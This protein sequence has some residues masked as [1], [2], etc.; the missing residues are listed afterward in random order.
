MEC[1]MTVTLLMKILCLCM[2]MCVYMCAPF[3]VSLPAHSICLWQ[4]LAHFT[5]LIVADNYKLM[6]VGNHIP[7]KV[8]YLHRNHDI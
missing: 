5:I 2:S 4:S 7:V 6:A 8:N 1:E 3:Y